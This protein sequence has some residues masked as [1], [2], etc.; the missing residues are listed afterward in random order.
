MAESG[1]RIPEVAIAVD[2][3]VLTVREDALQILLVERGIEPWQG[4]LA[5][6]GGFLEDN[7][8]DLDAAAE[9]ELAEE[10]GLDLRRVHLEQL[11]TYGSP[12]RD[13][14]RRVVTVCYLAF[15]PDLPAPEAGGDARAA[16]W[17]PVDSVLDGRAELAFD[18][19]RIVADAVERARSKLEYTTLATRFCPPEFTVTELRRVYEIVWGETLDQRNFHRKITGTEGALIS[20]GAQ[21][22]RQGGRP[23]TLYRCGPATI[24]HPAILRTATQP[25]LQGHHA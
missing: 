4:F 21:T 24:L 6:P 1:W 16:V 18:H 17:T 19:R 23:A 12:D 7:R 10:T 8:E 20:T 2:L 11:R 14:R 5:L 9:R 15:M 3:A 13:P 22:T 25:T